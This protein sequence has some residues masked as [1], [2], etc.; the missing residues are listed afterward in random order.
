MNAKHLS[1]CGAKIK[2]QISGAT[3]RWVNDVKMIIFKWTEHLG[4]FFFPTNLCYGGATECFIDA[5]HYILVNSKSYFFFLLL[6]ICFSWFVLC[7]MK[8]VFT[9]FM[10]DIH[11]HKKWPKQKWD[12]NWK[13]PKLASEIKSDLK[14]ENK[15]QNVLE[16]APSKLLKAKKYISCI[17]CLTNLH[18]N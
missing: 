10:Y 15:N 14:M 2:I 1:F 9:M 11:K 4:T 12:N 18:C 6:N 17:S 3:S 13:C 16:V 5:I 7:C 8:Y